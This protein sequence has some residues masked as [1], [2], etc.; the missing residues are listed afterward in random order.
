[1]NCARVASECTFVDDWQ[2]RET[3]GNVNLGERL[4]ELGLDVHFPVEA[5]KTRVLLLLL[6]CTILSLTGVAVHERS[7]EAGH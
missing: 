7:A 2:T 5:G 4:R 1:M 6:V 3:L